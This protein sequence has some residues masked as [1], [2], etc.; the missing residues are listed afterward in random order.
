DI[1]DTTVLSFSESFCGDIAASTAFAEGLGVVSV[2]A[3]TDLNHT[4]AAMV[5]YRKGTEEFGYVPTAAE[6]VSVGISEAAALPA[7]DVYPVPAIDNLRF[8]SE[9]TDA[10]EVYDLTGKPVLT[11]SLFGTRHQLDVSALSS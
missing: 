8:D 4:M 3:Y 2:A 5:G 11:Q 7:V 6:V 1:G 9:N 10:V